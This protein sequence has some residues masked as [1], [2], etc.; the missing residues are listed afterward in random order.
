[1]W[2]LRRGRWPQCCH[3]IGYY[4]E[5]SNS[6][7]FLVLLLRAFKNNVTFKMI[8]GILIDHY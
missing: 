6:R 2:D 4:E 7:N 1:M 5:K 8:I 3:T